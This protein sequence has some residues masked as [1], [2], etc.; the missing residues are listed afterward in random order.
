MAYIG[1]FLDG[2]S[3]MP[4]DFSQSYAVVVSGAKLNPC[5]HMLLYTAANGGFYVHV[6]EVRGRPRYMAREDYETYLM[7]NRK[8]ELSRTFVPIPNPNGAL[9]ELRNQMSKPWTWFVLPH[10]CAAFVET[11]LRAGGASAGLYLN[12]PTI[13]TFR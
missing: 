1:E 2:R 8:R 12:C 3:W 4:F 5:G 6:A 7:E 9:M 10:N 11:I 13:E